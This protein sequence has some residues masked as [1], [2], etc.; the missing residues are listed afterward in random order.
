VLYVPAAQLVQVL[1]AVAPTAVLYVPAGQLV[2]LETPTVVLYVP[3]AQSVHVN[4]PVTVLYVPIPHA[5]HVTPSDKAV[6]PTLQV[7]LVL[8]GLASPE[9]VPDGHAVQPPTPVNSLYVPIPHALHA[10]PSAPVY[11]AGHVQFVAWLLPAAED[12]FAGHP[13]HMLELDAPTSGL[14]V[15]TA[16]PLQVAVVVAPNVTEYVPAGQV[17]H[18]PGPC[19][20]L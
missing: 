4:A 20:S 9:L 13:R 14:Y 3:A 10:L 15:L 18:V 6:Y 2:Q 16:H 17:E 1:L 7:Q 19:W 8:D 5:L 12:E 11:P